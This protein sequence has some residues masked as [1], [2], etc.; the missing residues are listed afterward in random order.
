MIATVTH[1]ASSPSADKVISAAPV[2]AL[3]A[4]GSAILPKS[5]ILPPRLAS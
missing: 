2:R 5:V 3:S 1:H 4:I